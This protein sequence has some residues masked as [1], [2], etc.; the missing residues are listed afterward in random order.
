[1]EGRVKV[2]DFGLS[3]TLAADVQL[4]QPGAFLG[5]PQYCAPEQ[6]RNDPLDDQCDVYSVVATLYFTLTGQAPFHGSDALATMARVVSDPAP[7]ILK[8][9]P[10]LPR[11]LE[12]VI[13]KGL[14]RDPKR[15]WQSMQE[16]KKAL[17]EFSSEGALSA[18][19]IPRLGSFLIDLLFCFFGTMVTYVLS[20][21]VN[22]VG[23]SER[24]ETSLTTDVYLGAVFLSICVCYFTLCEGCWGRT[25]GKWL[26][27]IRV[28]CYKRP[29]IGLRHAIVRST[30]LA[31][32]CYVLPIAV[33]TA[34]S[35]L[36]FNPGVM[37][38]VTWI[39]VISTIPVT[40]ILVISTMRKRNGRRGLHELISGTCV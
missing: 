40:W 39:L 38:P 35:E 3:R 19:V 12:K 4:T 25:I 26:L 9:R 33:F 18:R 27:K 30:S 7:P 20:L 1:A 36:I 8:L 2:G 23:L 34:S 22:Q 15:R 11:G 10:D 17:L 31:L 28:R 37:I 24:D 6:I 29:E 16:L 21:Q 5:T 14:E 13:A 32:I